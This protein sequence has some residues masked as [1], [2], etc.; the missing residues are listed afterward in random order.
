MGKST[1]FDGMKTR[2]DGDFHGLLLL[3]SGNLITK[4]FQVPSNGGTYCTLFQAIFG[5]GFSLT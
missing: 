4:E 1:I 5:I 2:K 3:V